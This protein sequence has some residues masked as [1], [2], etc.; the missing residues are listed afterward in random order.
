MA[1]EG[2]IH[3]PYCADQAVQ[4]TTPL[5]SCEQIARDTY[6]VR[7]AAPEIARRCIPGQFVMMRMA[8]TS[9]PLIGRA[10]AI[11]DVIDDERGNPEEIDVVFVA[12]GKFTTTLA[13]AGCGAEVT[14]WGPLGN[15]FSVAPAE[16]LFI[17]VGG[18]G[19]TPMLMLS[20][21]A[22]GKRRFGLPARGSGY[23]SRVV[24]IYGA[25]SRDLLAGVD[26]F[27][28]TG[29]E[30]VLCSDDGSIG[31]T[32]RVPEVLGEILDRSDDIG[33]AR[34]VTCG[35]EMMMQKVATLAQQRDIPCEVSLE[36]PMACGIGICFT[37]VARVRQG[38]SGW[39]YKRTCVEGP[40]FDAAEIVWG[41]P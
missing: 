31:R 29:M 4:L 3:P 1:S 32:G 22:L 12:K 17:A 7:V 18:V 41:D 25:R 36:T 38:E 37:C 19:Q 23:A 10:L 26:A 35:P 20:Q 13:A 28:A 34:I 39:D 24:M 30:L 8:R 33:R 2:T 27:R 40:I 16:T 9:D 6:R 15:S 11:Y 21:E 5:A 14:L